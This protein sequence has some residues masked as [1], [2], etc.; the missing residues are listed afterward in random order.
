MKTIS[1]HPF[2]LETS[3]ALTRNRSP[4]ASATRPRLVV[5]QAPTSKLLSTSKP[6]IHIPTH[7]YM[8]IQLERIDAAL[9]QTL[10]LTSH[11]N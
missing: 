10:Q 11:P 7:I 4:A 5:T 1:N 2:S 6:S 8:S 9:L 3:V